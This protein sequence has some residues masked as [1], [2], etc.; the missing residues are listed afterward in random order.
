MKILAT[1]HNTFLTCCL[2]LLL[3]S[4]ACAQ[5]MIE[6]N[7]TTVTS[8]ESEAPLPKSASAP[9][10][11]ATPV[12]WGQGILEAEFLTKLRHFLER[13]PLDFKSFGL[14]FGI[15]LEVT[16]STGQHPD[17]SWAIRTTGPLPPPFGSE[18]SGGTFGAGLRGAEYLFIPTLKQNSLRLELLKRSS[19]IEQFSKKSPC[20]EPNMVASAFQQFSWIKTTSYGERKTH[21]G[22]V[23]YPTIDIYYYKQGTLDQVA[24]SIYLGYECVPYLSVSTNRTIQHPATK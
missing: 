15:T 17:G 1:H 23:P 5:K 13:D 16:P 18:N 20:I 8:A 4:I 3:T 19:K 24:L 10:T 22:L 21:Q 6:P 7:P 2:A 11:V 12:E 14:T 9:M